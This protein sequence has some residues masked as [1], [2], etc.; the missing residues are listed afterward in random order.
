MPPDT[1]M[2]H[3]HLYVADLDKTMHFYHTL[4]GFD[5]MGWPHLPHGNG[6]GRSYHHHI[7]FNTWLGEGIPTRRPMRLGYAT[8][9]SSCRTKLNLSVS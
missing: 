6:L 9:P 4:L 7:G 5:D 2:G 1:R 3:F 8:F